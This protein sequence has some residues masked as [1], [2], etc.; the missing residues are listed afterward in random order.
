MMNKKDIFKK[1]ST[2]FFYS[3]IFFPKLVKDEVFTLYAYVR[4][5]DDAV[6]Q[7]IPDIKLFKSLKKQT[8]LAW[9]GKKIDS[10]IVQNFIDL[11]KKRKFEWE[12]IQAFL[13]AMEKDLVKKSYESF[14]ELEEYMYGSAEVIGLMMAR[15]LSLPKEAEKAAQ[16]QGKAMQFINFIRDVQ[17]DAELG[18][19]YLPDLDLKN[20]KKNWS[21]IV[22]KSIQTYQK[23]QLEAEKGYTYIPYRYLVPIKT[24]AQMY[25]WTA[26]QILQNPEIV[27]SKKVKPNKMRVIFTALKNMILV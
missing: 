27:W 2:T 26:Q 25:T 22:R 7:V 10:V 12:W 21:E 11:A 16:L 15:I 18:R 13:H 19:T 23:I 24:A 6:D 3:S 4:I 8:E 1:G 17:E 9:Q 14:A 20:G 5:V